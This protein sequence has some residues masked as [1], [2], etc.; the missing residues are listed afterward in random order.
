[1]CRTVFSGNHRSVVFDLSRGAIL[2]M[3]VL[4]ESS[5]AFGDS[6]ISW[7]GQGALSM[8]KALLPTVY[9]SAGAADALVHLNCTNG[10]GQAM[11]N[12]G[13]LGLP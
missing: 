5:L 8:G 6:P 11:S 1:M 7:L 4:I 3:V 9:A 12:F 2:V 10:V 13:D